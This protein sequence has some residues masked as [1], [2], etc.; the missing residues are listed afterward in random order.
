MLD[1]LWSKNTLKME[2]KTAKSMLPAATLGPQ[3]TLKSPMDKFSQKV[4]LQISISST[5]TTPEPNSWS[6]NASETSNFTEN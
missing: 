6:K 2:P 3:E 1:R 4:D 5:K